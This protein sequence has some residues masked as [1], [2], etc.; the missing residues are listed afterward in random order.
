MDIPAILFR[1]NGLI[2]GVQELLTDPGK[3]FADRHVDELRPAKSRAE[4][5]TA[6][7]TDLCVADDAG[8]LTLGQGASCCEGGLGLILGAEKDKTAFHDEV[9]GVPARDSRRRSRPWSEGWSGFLQLDGEAC[10]GGHFVQRGGQPVPCAITLGGDAGGGG[11]TGGLPQ[12]AE[13]CAVGAEVGRQR[14]APAQGKDGGRPPACRCRRQ[15]TPA[16]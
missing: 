2:A 4:R 14:K 10:L 9:E 11:G 7:L 12:V 1:I 3:L 13:A 15:E 6:R 16:A 8:A 5:D